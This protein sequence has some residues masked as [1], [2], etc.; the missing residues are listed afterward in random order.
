[1]ADFLSGTAHL[2][3]DPIGIA[4]FLAGLFGGLLFGAI[5]GV[6]M[7][8]LG[9]VI[10]PFTAYMSATHAIMLY[11][12][13]YVSGVYGGAITAIL[14][15][16]PGSP[17]NAP[18]AFDGYPM[19]LQGK[20]G[21]AIGAAVVCSAA[22]G[23]ASAVLMMV[24]TPRIADW[25]VTAFGPPE[26][27][28]LVFFG[29]SVAAAVGAASLW[30]GWLSVLVG[31]LLA[32]VGTDPAGGLDR[33]SFGSYYLLA[34]IHFI[35][36]ILGF[37]AVSEVFIQGHRIATGAHM[38]ARVGVEF[39][40]SSEFWRL[41]FAALRSAILGFF[42]GVM[43]GIGAT[44][45]AFLSYNEAVRWS[46]HPERFGK[47]ELEGVVASETANNAATG[48][49]MIP[50][51]ALGLPGGALTAMMMGAF[52]IHGMD[53]GPLVFMTAHDLVWITFAA[54]FF[55]NLSILL[56]GFFETKTVV[57]L[58]R[59]PFRVLAPA[60]LLLATIGAY[61]LRNLLV[62]VWVMYLAGIAGYF[63]RRSGYSVAGIVLGLILGRL[64]EAAFV[65]SM[66]LM[67]YN[68]LGFF[69]RPIAA[70]LILFGL[71]T[72]VFNIVRPSKMGRQ[73]EE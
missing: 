5:P 51:L 62:D 54:M 53:P 22:G 1:M 31:L 3:G 58:L 41:K 44:L 50:L 15:N 36:L 71:I 72:I 37:F 70:G 59:I 57:H 49:A 35:P 63:L 27:F 69:E 20:S 52:Q 42:A 32:T 68:F 26:L 18:T 73:A 16:I 19:T 67:Q 29:L 21:K 61:A 11:A 34:G 10:L 60:I 39:P 7:L 6:N 13:I 33:F 23:T 24:A 64:G 4:I 28:A 40:T 46:R 38:P 45:A 9:A 47:G 56:L 8:T 48:A 25:A 14:F 66:Q 65:K 30:K 17:E 55:A 43:P 2:F 12:V